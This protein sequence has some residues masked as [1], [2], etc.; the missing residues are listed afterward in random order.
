MVDMAWKIGN[1][2]Q[3]KRVID[4]VHSRDSKFLRIKVIFLLTKSIF[5]LV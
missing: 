2:Y 5:G 3:G 1:L 4:L